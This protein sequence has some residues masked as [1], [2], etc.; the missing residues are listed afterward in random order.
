MI[1]EEKQRKEEQKVHKLAEKAQ[2][3]KS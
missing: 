3:A 1:Q 2:K